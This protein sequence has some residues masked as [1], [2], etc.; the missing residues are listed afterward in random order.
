MV[1]SRW[2]LAAL[3]SCLG[4]SLGA[5]AQDSEPATQLILVVDSDLERLDAVD[6]RVEAPNATAKT[7]SAA[8]R[9]SGDPIYLTLL[10]EQGPL[11]P[12]TISATAKRGV[13][14]MVTRTHVVSFVA[15]ESLVVPLHLVRSCL[16]RS[17]GSGQTCTERGCAPRELDQNDLASWS[18]TPPTLASAA[19]TQCDEGLI[20]LASDPEHC[21]DCG[22]ACSVLNSQQ[23]ALAT[24]SEGTCGI[25]CEALYGDCDD[26]ARNGC[27]RALTDTRHCGSCGNECSSTQR[28]S[29]GVCVKK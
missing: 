23:H 11:G 20:D 28:C 15:G 9:A 26:D 1:R 19:L 14:T 5:C 3:L 2:L 4:A 16:G 22:Q 12:L 24:C 21:G 13:L 7:A 29:A 6:F 10:R 8:P 17:C 25:A 27:E 18:G